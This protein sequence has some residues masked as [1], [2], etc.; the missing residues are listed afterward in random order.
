[1]S[2][3]TH[4]RDKRQHGYDKRGRNNNSKRV[5]LNTSNRERYDHRC[6]EKDSCGD[7]KTPTARNDKDFKPCHVHGPKSEHSYDECRHNP[8]NANKTNKSSF[9]VKKRGHD[10][11]YVDSHHRSSGDESPSEHDTPVPSDGEVDDD[12]SSNDKRSHS[13]YHIDDTPKKGRFFEKNDVGHKSPTQKKR[14]TLLEPDS[15][16]KKTPKANRFFEF[17]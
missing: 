16:M 3:Y 2:G 1:M 12:K 5:V 6:P 15:G 4:S 13:N 9:Y 7:G 17:R 14:K 8:K 11:H 10:A